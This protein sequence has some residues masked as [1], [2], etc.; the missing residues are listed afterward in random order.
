MRT[1][2]IEVRW[3]LGLSLAAMVVGCDDRLN[4][5]GGST[6]T[7]GTMTGTPGN[8]FALTSAGRLVTFDRAAPSIGTAM[9]VSGLQSGE[10]LLGIDIRPGGATPGQLYGLG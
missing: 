4:A 5:F 10:V 7:P 2:R 8:T 1:L 6:A 9:T 3:L